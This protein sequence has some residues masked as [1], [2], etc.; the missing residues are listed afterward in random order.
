MQAEAPFPVA[1]AGAVP[2]RDATL[3]VV[4]AITLLGLALRVLFFLGAD[5]AVPIRGDIIEYWNYAWNM[6]NHGVFS[7]VPPGPAIPAPD[8]WR[9]PGYPAFLAVMLRLGGEGRAIALALWFQILLGAL[10]P[11]LTFA[12]A[13]R[14]LRSPWPLVAGLLVA[15]WPHLVVFASTLLSETLFALALLLASLLVVWAQ[16]R[17]SVPLAAGAGGMAGLATLMNPL[18]ML[19]PPVVALLL[20]WREQRRSALA[21][22]LV[23]AAVMGA[24]SWRNSGLENA[25]ASSDRALANLVQGSWPRLHDAYRDR[26]DNEIARAYW[27]Q[28]QEETVQMRENPRAGLDALS[29]RLG[30]DPGTYLRWYLLQKPWLL[31]DWNVRIGWGDIYFLETQRSPFERVAALRAIRAGCLAINPIV[32][33]LAVFATLAAFWRGLRR[34]VQVP[35]FALLHSALLFAYVTAI[36]VVL[37]AEPRYSVAYRPIELLLAVAALAM[38]AQWLRSRRG[39]SP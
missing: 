23:F 1:G 28:V 6:V 12:L 7:S 32:F 4:L 38:A 14:W 30:A 17:K 34:R 39:A 11:P 8:A 5:I 3:T 37:Q 22:L 19:F 9:G 2:R 13:R 33:G 20:A 24:W 21:Y 16:T 18:L 25:A 26:F 36:H 31:W 15:I 27:D 10:L 29:H 35:D